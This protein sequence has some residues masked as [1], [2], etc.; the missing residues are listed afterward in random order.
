MDGTV[1]DE[2]TDKEKCSTSMILTFLIGCA[3]GFSFSLLVYGLTKDDDKNNFEQVI[4]SSIAEGKPIMILNGKPVML[5]ATLRK[6]GSVLYWP[7]VKQ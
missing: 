1:N 2:F 6:N 3:L 7:V 5:R 4:A